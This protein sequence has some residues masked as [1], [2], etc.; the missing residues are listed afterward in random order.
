MT[1]P[2][3]GAVTAPQATPKNRPAGKQEAGDSR[4]RSD[5]LMAIKMPSQEETQAAIQKAEAQKHQ[6]E[7]DRLKKEL[8][9]KGED[10]SLLYN[11]GTHYMSAG[12][13]MDAIEPLQRAVEL[14]DR[15]VHAL[16]NLGVVY[17]E[18]EQYERSVELSE[19]AV[20]VSPGFVP[21]RANLAMALI[22]FKKPV[23]AL[24]HLNMLLSTEPRLPVALAGMV[25]VHQMLGNDDK[26]AEYRKRAEAAGVV[27]KDA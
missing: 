27:F 12:R 14:D 9:E 7:I 26:V 20:A 11:L 6:L 24:K 15:F 2:R 13:W 19:K 5:R 16:T 21:A 25:Q 18:L 3:G 4:E 23:E 22:Q 8:D 10:K 17:Y 1:L